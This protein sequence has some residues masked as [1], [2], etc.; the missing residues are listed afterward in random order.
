[1]AYGNAQRLGQTIDPSLMRAD[2]SGYANAGA[3]LG[4]TLANVG[5][6]IGDAL[7][8]RA[9]SQKEID[10]GVKMATAIKTAIP[11]MSGMADQ[12]L[13]ELTNPELST[14]QKLASLRGIKEAMQ[15]SLLGKQ[16][17]RA[18]AMLK[19]Q[20]D[21]LLAKLNSG[22]NQVPQGTFMSRQEFSSLLS[23]GVP[24]KG[25]PTADGRI[26]VTDISG[27]QP[28]VLGSNVALIDGKPVQ[29]PAQKLELPAWGGGTNADTAA[30]GIIDGINMGETTPLPVDGAVLPPLPDQTQNVQQ[31]I[32]LTEVPKGDVWRMDRDGLVAGQI[33]GSMQDLE[34]QQKKAELEKTK[35]ETQKM[36]GEQGKQTTQAK[37][38]KD[39]F[40]S[41]MGEASN[42]YAN[43][44]KKGGAV[45]GGE[46]SLG[47]VLASTQA[48]Q[49]FGEITGSEA[50]QFRN[51]LGSLAPKILLGIMASTGLSA[52][53]LNSNAEL[54]LQLQSLGDPSKP[55]Q[56]NLAA[57]HTLDK[58]YGDGTAV[59]KMLKNNPELNSLMEKSGFDYGVEESK[60]S[61]V[62]KMFELDPRLR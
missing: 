27:N 31:G 32:P 6:K 4:N 38:S 52:T 53:Q 59:P 5:E 41:V 43:L 39:N 46:F 35:L 23:S 12:V 26:Y 11:Q 49:K 54:Q 19:L 50:Q 16:E 60:K 58:M 29:L 42:A 37:K 7:K 13:D 25:V 14:N 15:I 36:Q 62:L 9:E 44:Y 24:A 57:L 51:Y 22:K 48:G 34:A 17:S 61:D 30:A 21:E 33:P 55:I 47:Q 8:M 40:S 18:D 56:S 28:G 1:M 2:Y 45:V 10:S 20:Q 3:I